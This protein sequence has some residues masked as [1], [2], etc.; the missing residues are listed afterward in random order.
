MLTLPRHH[1]MTWQWL[2]AF[3]PVSAFAT[4][5]TLP[6]ALVAA[7][8]YS[9]ELSASRHQINALDNRADSA[10]QLPDPK[11]KFGI[12]NL[13]SAAATPTGLPVKG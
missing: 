6:Q 9:A 8:D 1:R 10:M 13:R 12:E 3:V 4:P 5:V 7:Q 2:L 11:L